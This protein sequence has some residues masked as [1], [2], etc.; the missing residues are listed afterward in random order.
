LAQALPPATVIL[1]SHDQ[2]SDRYGSFFETLAGQ[3][4]K[5]TCTYSV[6]RVA[7]TRPSARPQTPASTACL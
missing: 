2:V 6:G 3:K 1:A 5:K 4:D 7:A